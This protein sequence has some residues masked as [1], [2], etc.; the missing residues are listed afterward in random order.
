MET[1][2]EGKVK[3][4]IPKFKKVSS[5]APVFYNPAM[6]FDRDLSVIILQQFQKEINKEISVADTFGASGIRGIRYFKEVKN[7]NKVFINDIDETAV[8]FIKKNVALNNIEAEVSQEEA[9]I[10]LRKNR[11]KFDIIDIDPF[12][13]PSPF[14]DS[15]LY[16]AKRDSLL[17]I[18]ATDTSALCGT[19]RTAC[20]RKYNSV[21]LKTEYCHENAVRILMA[22]VAMNGAKYDKYIVPKFS[23]STKHYVRL[24]LKVKK[25]LK[26][27]INVLTK[28]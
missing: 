2:R 21:P 11:G 10:F 7:V 9:N 27:Q 18:T 1:I 17:C 25:E 20:I 6:K 4:K 8:K 19:Y 3:I 22:F 14:I 23:H 26:R 13:T 24:Y 12:G 5:E 16:S 15:T 28:T